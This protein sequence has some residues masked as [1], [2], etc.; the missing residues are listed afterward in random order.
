MKYNPDQDWSA[1]FYRGL[2]A[3]QLKDGNDILNI[4][5]DDQGS[6]CLNTLA[7]HDKYAT[8]C[9]SKEVPLTNKVDYVNKYPSTLQTTPYN[10]SDT[11]ITSE[12]CTG[13]VKATPLHSKNQAQHFHDLNEIETYP[14]VQPAFFNYLTGE[15]KRKV[16]VPVDGGHDKGPCHKEVQFW[17]TCYHFDKGC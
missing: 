10:F 2:D 12:T 4:N 15:Q 9:I 8:L 17:W 16:C 5:R 13:I 6:F 1:A 11:G 7:T 3:L 14:D